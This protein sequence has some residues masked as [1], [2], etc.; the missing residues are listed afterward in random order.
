[1]KKL[2]LFTLILSLALA[3]PSLAEA[4]EPVRIDWSK[5]LEQA[6][7]DAGFVGTQYT[8]HGVG[9]QL[10]I[11]DSYVEQ[12]ITD[13]DLANE[14]VFHY[15]DEE[16]GGKIQVFDS[17]IESCDDLTGLGEMLKTQYPDRL[18]QHVIINGVPAIINA[19]EELDTAN[20]IFDMGEHRF[21]QIVFSPMSKA[22]QLLTLCIASIQFPA[23]EG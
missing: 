11:P 21:V 7:V 14:L 19:S 3:M 20:V 15:A 1:M 6:F 16:N 10:I 12:S 17:I 5:E 22:N 9:C 8:L 18:V 23:T 13:E 4:D 2:I